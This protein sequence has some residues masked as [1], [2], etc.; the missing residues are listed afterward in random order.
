M[1]PSSNDGV[2]LRR[3]SLLRTAAG[4][5]AVGAVAAGATTATAD[6]AGDGDT[7]TIIHDTHFH[8]RFED[9][10]DPGRNIARYHTVVEE[11]REEHENAAFLG[12]GDEFAP[13]LLGMEFEGAHMVEALNYMEPDAVGAGNHEFDFG[14]ETATE[15]FED[16]EFPWVIANLLDPDGNPVPGTER[17]TTV[18]VGDVT[19]GV[20]GLGSRSFHDI[21]D[22]PDD[23]QVLDPQEAAEEAVDALED[24]AD[25][26]VGAVHISTGAQRSLAREVEGLDAVVGSHSGV[27]YDEP[28]ELDGT[29]VSEFGDEFEYVGRLTFDVESGELVDWERIQFYNS[30]LLDDDEEPPADDHDNHEVVDVH[31]VEEDEFLDEL[32]EE[33][34][35]DLEDRL[36]DRTFETGSELDA[37]FDPNYARETRFGNLMTD[38][39]RDVG[40]FDVDVAVQNAGGIRSNATYG[41]GEVSGLEVMDILPFPNEIEVYEL[42]GEHLLAY[43]EDATRPMPGS[44]GAQPAIQVSGIQYEWWGHDGEV[45]ILDAYVGDEPLD[46]DETY[47]VTSNDF[48]A[49]RSVIA[50]EGELVERA[51]QFLGPYLLDWLEEQ[52][53]VDPVLE[54]RM[55]RV[56]EDVGEAASIEVDGDEVTIWVPSPGDAADS[57]TDEFRLIARTGQQA[58]ATGV[59]DEG[60]AIVVSFDREEAL[61]LATGI[62]EP[63]LRVLGKFG[64]DD[65]YYGY[66]EDG[67]LMELPVSA[68]Y[69]YFK[70][71]SEVSADAISAAAETPTPTQT[72]EPTP[73]PEPGPADDE[74]APGLGPLAALLG[75]GGAAAYAAKRASEDDE[76][77]E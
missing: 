1:C 54:N 16:S 50:E 14:V 10:D 35:S 74:E 28:E 73:S 42:S 64:P 34:T 52:G 59:E 65:E 76:A 61:N 62:Q 40:D 47:T 33:Y 7:V 53:T 71:R 27:V 36:G 44:F 56:D 77:S 37:R 13:S 11:L 69:D 63:G 31:D 5:L 12:I 57:I 66:E 22:Y 46:P 45:E 6:A 38:A 30:E 15:H 32:T 43:L 67:E 4:G 39:M 2:E 29:V 68:G 49:G 58:E 17:W 72:A 55:I 70:L 24:E 21:T 25:L 41:P 75:A 9:G 18:E 8:G 3:R 20:F 51:G 26:I 19:L 48:E 23:W 60:D